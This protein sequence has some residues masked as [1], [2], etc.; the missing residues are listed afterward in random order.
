M[1]K[2]SIFKECPKCGLRNKPNATQC[3][4]CGQS[5]RETDD[6]QQHLKDLESLNNLE[7][8]KPVDDR[9]SRRI[10]ATIIRKDPTP[11]R[12]GG[13]K[14]ASDIRKAFEDLEKNSSV[15][16][17]KVGNGSERSHP[18]ERPHGYEP[19]SLKD[20]MPMRGNRQ[21]TIDFI[22][23]ERSTSEGAVDSPDEDAVKRS[24]VQVAEGEATLD[25]PQP[26]PE[27]LSKE[28]T[29]EIVSEEV[30]QSSENITERA[31]P[32][33]E[34]PDQSVLVE[35]EAPTE[36]ATVQEAPEKSPDD[37]D[38]AM[39]VGEENDEVL[40]ET[41]VADVEVG[42]GPVEIRSDDDPVITVSSNSSTMSKELK[43]T[44][45]DGPVAPSPNT[46]SSF[47]ANLARS[48][49]G[50]FAIGGVTYLAILALTAI[51]SLGDFV[52]L[53]GGAITSALVI[54]GAFLS[55]PSLKS[56][57]ENVVLICPLCHERV[58]K[59]EDHCPSCGSAFGSENR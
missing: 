47:R 13:I 38:D 59:D 28:S 1:E 37:I 51:G 16:E 31:E 44:E 8:R 27:I 19:I 29:D 14:E 33:Q 45:I 58:D 17:I 52:S 50:I 10:E 56:R 20:Q 46:F 36:E 26:T 48:G 22:E 43:L 9:T 57:N 30:R 32:V 21:G 4:F 24:Q 42:S 39:G 34:Q 15:I 12:I 41:I 53:G 55:Y 6:W 18:T 7:L 2:R 11:Q 3:D 23:L 35:N 5:L 49:V 54:Y 40:I 25:R